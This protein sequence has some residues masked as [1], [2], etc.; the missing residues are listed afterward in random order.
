MAFFGAEL[1][2][3]RVAAGLSQEQ[4]GRRLNFSGDLAGKI[5]TCERAPTP[6]FAEGCDGVFPHMD[7]LFTR[8]LELARRWD[9]PYP[10]WFRDWLEAEQGATSLR[11][12][13]PMVIPGLL[14]TT[15]Y[16]R[17]ILAAGPDTMADELEQM[18]TARSSG[19]RSWTGPGRRPCGWCWM[20]TCCAGASAR[21]RS[22]TSSCCTWPT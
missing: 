19:R 8:L 5:E 10:Q 3:A 18:V 1:R 21:P 9:G 20:S 11:W 14:Q 7:G 17:A 6:G 15:D 12:W 22:C 2:Q 13:E 4:L 16:A